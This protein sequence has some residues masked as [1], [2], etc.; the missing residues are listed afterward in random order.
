M[1]PRW[2]FEAHVRAEP[3]AVYAWLAD[4]REDDHARPAYLRGAGRADDAPA[5]RRAIL[6]REAGRMRVRD[7]W[8]RRS[9]ETDVELHPEAREVRITGAYGYRGVWRARPHPEGG[10]RLTVEGEMA[11]EGF[12]RL[13]APLMARMLRGEMRRDFE[14]HVA[15]LRASLHA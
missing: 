4:L 7:E 9:F 1:P 15:D 11:P 5:S 14:G 13:V 2:S 12:L 6:S 3:D 8:G 10:T